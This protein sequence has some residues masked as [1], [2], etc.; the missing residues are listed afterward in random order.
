M[1]ELNIHCRYDSMVMIPQLRPHPK[2]RN[3]HPAAQIDRLAK[4]IA[5]QGIRAPIVV[6]KRSGF[7]VK[8]HGTLEAIKQNGCE[9]APVVYQDFDTEDQEYAFV[10][11][12]NSIASWADLDLSG[13]NADLADLGP[14]FNIE[15]LGIESFTLDASEKDSKGM[16][17]TCP[18]CQK[19]FAA[20]GQI[21]RGSN[22]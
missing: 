12:D 13:I 17:V 15:H 4:I 19:Q 22:A 7:I 2:N 18:H 16:M 14:D 11:S 8:G 1:A 6:S 20:K 9:H 10:Q 3:I 21:K 5:Y